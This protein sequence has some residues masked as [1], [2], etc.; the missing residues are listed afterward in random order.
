MRDRG[1]DWMD[2]AGAGRYVRPADRQALILSPF[3]HILT[4]DL[5]RVSL[6]GRQ[7][8]H[9]EWRLTKHQPSQMLH[10]FPQRN[11]GLDRPVS[12]MASLSD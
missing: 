2:A 4:A 1:K 10:S 6:Q 7:M 8:S 11:L 5:V 3:P 12:P 9:K